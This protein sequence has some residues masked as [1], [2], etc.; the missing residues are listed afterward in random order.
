MTKE[1]W[2]RRNAERFV[3]SEDEI[4]KIG[5]NDNEERRINV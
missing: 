5:E 3:S 1:E 4:I 2:L